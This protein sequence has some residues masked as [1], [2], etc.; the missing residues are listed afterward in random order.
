MTASVTLM[1]GP[2]R[3]C[4]AT[5]FPLSSSGPHVCPRCSAGTAAIG[6]PDDRINKEIYRALVIEYGA[7]ANALKPHTGER[8]NAW[9][10][11][12][13]RATQFR[14]EGRPIPEF[15]RRPLS[16]EVV[17][18]YEA[19]RFAAADIIASRPPGRIAVPVVV[20]GRMDI[21]AR[22]PRVAV[23]KSG[24]GLKVW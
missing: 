13:I 5:D 12:V 7:V 2:C 22:K 20:K 1:R 18:A 23:P 19:G 15:L 24:A 11:R 4:G 21:E 14:R 10:L 16:P 17:E 3:W 8:F 6:P 9:R